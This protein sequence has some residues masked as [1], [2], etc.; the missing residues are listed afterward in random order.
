[1]PIKERINND[2]K[3]AMLS[4]D[5]HTVSILRGLK[6]SILY[7]EVEKNKRTE[8]LTEEETVS[9]LQKEAKKRQESADLY[10]QGGNLSKSEDEL[11][12]K[13]V[14]EGYLP[15]QISDDELAAAVDEAAQ[16][17]GEFSRQ[18]MGAIIGATKKIVGAAADGSRI[19]SFVNRR[20]N[21]E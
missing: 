1:M 3:S 12:E 9:L 21:S 10:K 20:I 18:N 5:Q 2:L 13:A 17:V 8:G 4:R 14:I 7:V 19:A 11:K 16:E 15:R 6:S